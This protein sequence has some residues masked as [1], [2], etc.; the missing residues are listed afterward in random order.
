MRRASWL[1]ECAVMIRGRRVGS[2]ADTANIRILD[3]MKKG[4]TKPGLVL[5]AWEFQLKLS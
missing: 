3:D 5:D 2:K 4:S 1:L